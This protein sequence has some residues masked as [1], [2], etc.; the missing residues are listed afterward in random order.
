MYNSRLERLRILQKKIV[1]IITKS[2]YLAHTN[3]LFSSESILKIDDIIKLEVA[4]FMYL[5]DNNQAPSTFDNIFKRNNE[6]H[7]HNTEDNQTNIVPPREGLN[8]DRTIF[9]FVHGTTGME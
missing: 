3:P 5:F 7:E 9:Y 4:S 1:R 6:I 2:P 8:S